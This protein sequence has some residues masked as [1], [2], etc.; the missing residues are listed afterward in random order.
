MTEY[1]SKWRRLNNYLNKHFEFIVG[2]N[3][4]VWIVFFVARIG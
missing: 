4:G 2:V 1:Q 3:V